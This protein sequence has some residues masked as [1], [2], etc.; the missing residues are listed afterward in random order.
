VSAAPRNLGRSTWGRSADLTRRSERKQI[1]KAAR[2]GINA[3]L[4]GMVGWTAD[5]CRAPF[6]AD[7]FGQEKRFSGSRE[8]PRAVRSTEAVSVAEQRE[9]RQVRLKF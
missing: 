2:F 5:F 1:L 6:R 3:T 9:F 8:N 7:I 4:F